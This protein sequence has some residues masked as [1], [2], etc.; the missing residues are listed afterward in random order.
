MKLHSSVRVAS[1]S[2]LALWLDLAVA[3]GNGAAANN[4]GPSSD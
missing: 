3:G 4:G 1:A 2:V